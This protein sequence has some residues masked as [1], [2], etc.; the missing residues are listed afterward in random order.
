MRVG[1]YKPLLGLKADDRARIVETTIDVL[2]DG[3]PL[4]AFNS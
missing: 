3:T 2:S 4:V 1:L